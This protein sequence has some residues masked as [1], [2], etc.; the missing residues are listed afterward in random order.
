[1]LRPI[2]EL[3]GRLRALDPAGIARRAGGAFDGRSLEFSYWQSTVRLLWPELTAVHAEDGKPC[4]TF[5]Q[6]MLLYYLDA[7]DGA[8]LAG[9]WIGYRELPDGGFYHQAYQGYSG[10]RLARAFGEHPQ[11]LPR[12]AE[13]LGGEFDGCAGHAGVRLQTPAPHPPGGCAVAWRRRVPRPW[14]HPV[15]RRQQPLHDDRRAGPAG[16]RAG[17]TAGTRSAAG[18]LAWT[19]PSEAPSWNPTPTARC[20]PNSFSHRTSGASAPAGACFCRPSCSCL[21]D[22]LLDHRRLRRPAAAH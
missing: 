19:T 9:R 22:H 15:R 4:A 16:R 5:D 3:A 13:A 14:R 2:D 20:S 8:P 10:D 6:A 17:G 21:P 7:A 1:M 18:S 12:A 11:E